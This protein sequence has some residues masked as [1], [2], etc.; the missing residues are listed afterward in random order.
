MISNSMER[1]G[2][3]ASAYLFWIRAAIHVKLGRCSRNDDKN[4]GEVQ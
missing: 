4:E 2:Y 1:E 3:I